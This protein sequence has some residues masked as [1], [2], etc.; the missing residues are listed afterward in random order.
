MNLQDYEKIKALSL[1]L[2]DKAHII[3]TEEEKNGLEVADFGLNKIEDTG[4]QLHT[5]VNTDLVCAKELAL[6]PNQTCPEHKHPKRDFDD[7]KEETFRC[8]YGTVYLYVEGEETKNRKMNPPQ[9]DEK[10]YTAFNEIILQPGEQ[11]TIYP[12]TL[13]WFKSGSEGAV[14]S[15]FSTRSTDDSDI[16]TDPRIKRIPELK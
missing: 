11:Y 5:Y 1:K 8:R 2:F 15:E 10:Y 6:L 12:N 16:F 7:G 9:G 4:L 3:L 14:V 13:H